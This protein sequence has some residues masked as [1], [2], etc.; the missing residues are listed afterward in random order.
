MKVGEE[1]NCFTLLCVEFVLFNLG[2]LATGLLIS[3][4]YVTEEGCD[5]NLLFVQV[6]LAED[7]ALRVAV[8]PFEKVTAIVPN[9][10]ELV[11]TPRVFTMG[12]LEEL[13]V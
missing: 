13:L 12:L 9:A 11:L 6:L 2:E 10:W 7:A 8:V 3:F 5:F 1:C 4:D